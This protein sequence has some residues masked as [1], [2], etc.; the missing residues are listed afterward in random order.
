LTFTSVEPHDPIKEVW[1]RMRT[2]RK[3]FVVAFLVFL[4]TWVGDALAG[5]P[6]TW[7]GFF[8]GLAVGLVVVTP[9]RRRID[10]PRWGFVFL[11]IGAIICIAS[12][13]V[14]SHDWGLTKVL[15]KRGLDLDG[16]TTVGV[17]AGGILVVLGVA[18][19]LTSGAKER[20]E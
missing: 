9:L 16:L 4:F 14:R 5:I 8:V 1:K 18:I 3:I 10:Q 19:L 6:G 7:C 20:S 12:V 17:V 13:G 11:W 15:D 2:L